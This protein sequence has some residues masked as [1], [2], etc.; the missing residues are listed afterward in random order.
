MKISYRVFCLPKSGCSSDE[1]E[2]AFAPDYSSESG[3]H[4]IDCKEFRCAVADGAT[5]TSFSGLWA[6]MLC[7]A[8]VDGK[9]DLPE[10]A[11]SWQDELSGMELPWYAEEK[12][13]EGAFATLLGLHLKEEKKRI[14]WSSWALGDSCLLHLREGS[15]LASFP[16]EKWQDFDYSPYLIS[17][18]IECNEKLSEMELEKG[19]SCIA[20]D[21][22]YLMT[23]AVSQ[24]ILRKEA[25]SGDG[26]SSLESVRTMAE[27]QTLVDG[28]RQAKDSEGR[29]LMH[30][31]DVTWARISLS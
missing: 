28:Q 2:D 6:G 19:G 22:F 4:Q 31:D 11:R 20:G 16:L 26:I 18:R 24:W 7:R 27:F 1:Y 14:R 17:S 29:V 3:A 8:Y 21:I 10:L 13:Q 9:L 30:N 23:D 5:E 15:M 25:E 12:L